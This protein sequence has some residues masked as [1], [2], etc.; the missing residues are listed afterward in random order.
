MSLEE[1]KDYPLSDADIR[2]ILGRDIS[3]LTYPD[4]AQMN[5]IDECFD[6]KYLLH[7]ANPIPLMPLH[8]LRFL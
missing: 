3:I 2:T 5:S 4:L 1:V 7:F 6:D 8:H